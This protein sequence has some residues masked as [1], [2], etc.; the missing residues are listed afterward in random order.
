MIY[1]IGHQESYEQYYREYGEAW[2]KGVG[3]SVWASLDE[4][5]KAAQESSE[6]SQRN[7]AVY[8]V[9]ADWNKDAI[10]TQYQG[11]TWRSLIKPAKLM[12][13]A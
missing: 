10:P 4:A 11:V 1:T 7:Y 8:G 6:I 12:K 3:G 5:V 2:A 9:E 13:L